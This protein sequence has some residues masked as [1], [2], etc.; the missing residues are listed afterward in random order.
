MLLTAL[1]ELPFVPLKT[2]KIKSKIFTIHSRSF[3]INGPSVIYYP[4]SYSA[5]L[6]KLKSNQAR[7]L[8]ARELYAFSFI[9]SH[10]LILPDPGAVFLPFWLAKTLLFIYDPVKM[11]SIFSNSFLHHLS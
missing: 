9:V 8:I 7:L 6:G 1:Q 10:C 5:S 2:E 3:L 11:L 4:I